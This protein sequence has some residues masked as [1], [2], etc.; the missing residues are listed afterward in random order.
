MSEG[1]PATR[2]G[3]SCGDLNGIGLEVILKTFEDGRML[4]EV[5]PVLYANARVVSQ[6]RKLL[7][8]EEVQFHR[9]SDAV[10]ALPRKLNV[11]NAWEEDLTVELGRPSG[12]LAAYAI[13][14]LE[15]ATHDLAAG[16][17]DVLVTAPIDK[18]SMETAGFAFPG[19]TEYLAHVAGVE[20]V[21]MELIGEGLCVG[22]VT[23]HIP[24][25]DVA[26]AISTEK[27]LVKTRSLHQSLQRDLA[28]PS[29]RIALLGLNPHA[30]DSGT[31]G[32]EDRERILPAVRQLNTEGILAMGP[33][34][35][36]GF[37]GN[38]TFEHFDGI[39]AMYHDQGLIPFK[40][41]AFGHG[42]NFTAGL[43]I[44]RTSPDHGTGLDIAGK[45]VADEGSFR[46]AVWAA[47]DIRANR[48][49]YKLLT[50]NP[51]RPQRTERSKTAG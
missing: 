20:E 6:H 41:I 30:G 36:D 47:C 51:L 37:F 1:T 12:S 18:H 22:M 11:V 45:G 10:E 24:L 4:Q 8:L 23:G 25:K 5:T 29:P 19:H 34:A 50:A 17:V 26:Q 31:L 46:A 27:I 14:S 38:G 7:D 44:V 43:P 40:T 35:A 16:K 2:V 39:M 32:T 9:V 13:R 49:R 28:V 42:V 48:E 33:Y 21:L 3:I 15:T